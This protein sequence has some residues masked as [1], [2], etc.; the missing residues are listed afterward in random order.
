MRNCFWHSIY[1]IEQKIAFPNVDPVR[2]LFRLISDN[3]K[4][5][6]SFFEKIANSK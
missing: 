4:N 3:N 1:S 2:N 6:N 5:P